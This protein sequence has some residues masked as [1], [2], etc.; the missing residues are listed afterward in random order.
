MARIK[1][2]F[3]RDVMS[4]ITYDKGVAKKLVESI[5]RLMKEA[6][7]SGDGVMISG[8]GDFR[9]RHKKARMGRNPKTKIEY[10]ISERSVVTFHPSKVFKQQLYSHLKNESSL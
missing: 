10:E 6:L 7:V 3:I 8:F 9:V 1:E 2:D 4:Q 5:L